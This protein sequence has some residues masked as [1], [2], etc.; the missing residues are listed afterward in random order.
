MLNRSPVFLGRAGR[1]GIGV[2]FPIG[3]ENFLI[4]LT[5]RPAVT[6]TQF[7][8]RGYWMLFPGG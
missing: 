3:Q 5:S 8:I 6:P 4:S 2:R 7:A 1:P